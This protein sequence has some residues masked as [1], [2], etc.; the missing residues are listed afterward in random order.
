MRV[1]VG[2]QQL[3]DYA[4]AIEILE[5]LARDPVWAARA[6]RDKGVCEFLRGS[7][8]K[9]A[10]DLEEAVRRN[11]GLL[12]AYVS[13]ASVYSALGREADE[14]RVTR[15]GLAAVP[16]KDE[17]SYRETLMRTLARLN[18]PSSR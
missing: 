14:L 15:L 12:S 3:R 1:A 4:R 18:R 8:E 11:P 13:L 17:R 7:K 6:L 16:E 10:S 5:P 2:Y 9:A